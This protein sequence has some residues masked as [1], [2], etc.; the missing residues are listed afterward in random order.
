MSTIYKKVTL[1]LFFFLF[2]LSGLHRLPGGTAFKCFLSL[3]D[4]LL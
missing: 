4:T 2:F 3:G 1:C